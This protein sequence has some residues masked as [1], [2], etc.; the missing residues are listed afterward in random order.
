MAVALGGTQR[1]AAVPLRPGPC[2]WL[3]MEQFQ[4]L[5][6][7]D[8]TAKFVEV[9]SRHGFHVAFVKGTCLVAGHR[10]P[11]PFLYRGTGNGLVAR[12]S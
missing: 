4:H 5:L 9:D 6:H 11:F 2:L 10:S 8:L 12:F 1:T 7:R 3:E